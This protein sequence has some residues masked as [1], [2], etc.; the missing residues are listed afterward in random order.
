MSRALILG[1]TGLIG[2]A[3]AARLLDAGWEVTVTGRDPAKVP[4]ELAGAGATFLAV[5]RT[6]AAALRAAI[7]PTTDLLVDVIGYTAAHAELL[8]PL[9]PQVGSTVFISAKA[10]YVD[11]AGRHA[12]SPEPPRFAGPVAETQPTLAPTRSVPYDTAAGYGANKVAAEQVLLDSGEPV[13]V[14]RPSKV[15]GAGASPPREWWWVKRAL[16]RRPVVLLAN[17]GDSRESPTAA[18]NLA[19]LVQTAAGRPGARILN[20]ADPDCPSTSEMTQVI[21]GWLGHACEEV[22]LDDA[23]P[24]G[25]GRTP[26]DRP[27]PFVLDT[28]AARAL[29]YQP[30]GDYAATVTAE[31]D[32]LVAIAMPAAD[33]YRLP[34]YVDA[35]AFTGWF[36]YAAE[37][38]YLGVAG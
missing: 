33:G 18:A 5:E 2:R 16:D 37:D 4:P 6:D 27:T 26:W 25:L 28:S 17:R 20:A 14:V 24:T 34:S 13:T 29:G 8:L 32:W 10:V 22:R 30:V 1:G 21:A 38:A 9:L 7:A 23:A 3:T 11:D 35:T 31:L 12:N 15:H 36:D 19:A